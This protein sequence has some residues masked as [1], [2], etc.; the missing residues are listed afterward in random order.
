MLRLRIVPSDASRGRGLIFFFSRQF[1]YGHSTK[2]MPFKIL[3]HTNALLDFVRSGVSLDCI[4]LF[5]AP[6]PNKVNAI[7]VRY[8]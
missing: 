5:F 4:G 8:D 6:E 2:S 3:F 1:F 7:F